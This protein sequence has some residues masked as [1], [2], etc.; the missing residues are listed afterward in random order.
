MTR[1]MQDIDAVLGGLPEFLTTREVC[2]LLRI[3]DETLF[4]WV[5]E[6]KFPRP[7]RPTSR[8]SRWPKVSVRRWLLDNARAD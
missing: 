2:A 8:T 7:L 1:F 3:K 5:K 6:G 4:E